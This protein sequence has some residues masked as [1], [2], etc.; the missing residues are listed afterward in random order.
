M[1]P[2]L[3]KSRINPPI[4]TE[5]KNISDSKTNSLAP[6]S[7]G[8][9][10]GNRFYRWCRRHISGFALMICFAV[11][12]GTVTGGVIHVFKRCIIFISGFFTPLI[13]DDAPNWWIVLPPIAGIMLTIIISRFLL[14]ANLTHLCAQLILRVKN[15]NYSMK[16]DSVFSGILTGSITLGCGGSSGAEGPAAYTGAAIGSNIARLFRLPESQTKVFLAC[17]ASAG[18]AAIFSAPVGGF[19]FSIELLRI[20]ISTLPVIA[21]MTSCLTAFMFASALD[22]FS[23]DLYFSPIHPEADIS[24]AIAALLGIV[25][26]LYSIY[27]SSVIN[28]LD[29]FYKN[30]SNQWARGI[31]GAV[32]I[33]I[34]LLLFPTM[35][36]IGYPIIGDVING[37]Y[38]VISKGCLLSFLPGDDVT[39][40]AA[41]SGILLLK[42]WAVSSTNSSGGVG[43]DFAP[44]LYAGCMAGFLFATVCNYSF[45]TE[46][47]VGIIA[48]L[49][50]AGVMAG[51][52]QA[53]LMAIFI[54]LEMCQIYSLAMPV[55]VCA[56]VS[57]LTVRGEALISADYKPIVRHLYWFGHKL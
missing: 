28:R 39:L 37:D 33:G 43:G 50:M 49:G 14:H 55:A 18:I 38:S 9:K 41:A 22:G 31:I 47:P 2:P 1:I 13:T 46:F 51:A 4:V 26:G 15:K 17:G 42:C 11:I 25:C 56:I 23:P 6:D 29:I 48:Y 8:L 40:M 24:V 16:P 20:G 36:S 21:V 57:Y 27:Y 30:I 10:T 5:P 54:V 34:I 7:S 45:G 53:P 12:I 35:F 52:I 3:L 44:T 19:L 32:G